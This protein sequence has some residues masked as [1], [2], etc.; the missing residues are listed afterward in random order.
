MIYLTY[1]YGRGGFKYTNLEYG[2]YYHKSRPGTPRVVQNPR[3]GSIYPNYGTVFFGVSRE[4][5]E[6]GTLLCFSFTGKCMFLRPGVVYGLD[7][8]FTKPRVPGSEV[9]KLFIKKQQ[10]FGGSIP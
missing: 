2:P 8:H 4:S 1:K 6:D 3:L 9:L 5:R 10:I 7:D